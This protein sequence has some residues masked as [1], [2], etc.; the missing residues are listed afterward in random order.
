MFASDSS[1]YGRRFQIKATGGTQTWNVR[2]PRP[3]EFY[4]GVPLAVIGAIG[5]TSMVVTVAVTGTKNTDMNS[6]YVVAGASVG[7]AVVGLLFGMD[8][9]AKADLVKIEE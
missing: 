7:V 3:W 8:A 1:F 9:G 5:A 6:V 4:V 2:N